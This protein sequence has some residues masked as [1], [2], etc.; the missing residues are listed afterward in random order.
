MV[1]FTTAKVSMPALRIAA[2]QHVN[3]VIGRPDL[4]PPS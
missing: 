1:D 2:G 4:P 3:L